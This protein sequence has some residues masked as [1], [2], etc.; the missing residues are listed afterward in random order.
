M[1]FGWGGSWWLTSMCRDT[2]SRPAM[3]YQIFLF[4]RLAGRHCIFAYVYPSADTICVVWAT[5]PLGLTSNYIA[6]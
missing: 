6:S 1:I 5:R 2:K 4:F 3:G